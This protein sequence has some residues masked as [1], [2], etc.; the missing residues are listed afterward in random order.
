M[1]FNSRVWSGKEKE[2]SINTSVT[3]S[4]FTLLMAWQANE[5]ESK[6]LRWAVRYG[7]IQKAGW[8]RWQTN[9]SKSAS[10][11]GL[12]ARFF[13]RVRVHCYTDSKVRHR[14]HKKTLD[15]SMFYPQQNANSQIEQ[16]TERTTKTK[17]RNK[18]KTDKVPQ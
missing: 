2:C 10:C 7:F 4:K 11:Q 9:V 13:Y 15:T 12:D 6:V 3:K 16:Y 8:P 14:H 5:S 18:Q 1:K 17:Q